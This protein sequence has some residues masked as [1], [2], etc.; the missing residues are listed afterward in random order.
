MTSFPCPWCDHLVGLPPPALT[1]DSVDSVV[2]LECRTQL[3][4]AVLATVMPHDDSGGGRR[5]ALAA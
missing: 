5:L 4:V 1:A 3:D 2:C